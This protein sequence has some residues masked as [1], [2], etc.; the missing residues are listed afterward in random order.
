[1]EKIKSSKQL[2]PAYP[3]FVK[4]PFFSLW[5]QSDK[6]NESDTVFWTGMK[7][8]S[9]GLVHCDGVAYSFMGIVENTKALE[10]T[11]VELTAFT[12][13]YTFTCEK[14]DLKV[15]FISPLPLKELDI[16]ALPVCYLTYEIT[17]KQKLEKCSIAF[18]LAEDSCYDKYAMPVRGGIHSLPQGETA[19]FGLKKQL[20]MSQST[21]SSAAEWGHWFLTG[22]KAM[23]VDT[24]SIDHFVETG[25]FAFYCSDWINKHLM[26]INTHD[27]VETATSGK[28]TLAFDDSI[29]IFY[30]GDWLKGYWFEDGKD[31]FDAIAY[32]HNEYDGILALLDTYEKD[33]V[34]R[35]E[36][37]GEDY[38][39]VLYGGLRQS[40][41][42]HKLVKNRKG[43]VAFLSKECHSNG[44]I[45]TVDV[46]YPSVPLY[47]LYNPELVKGML[48]PVFEFAEMP[49]WTYDFAP[50]D[51]GTY[52][53]VLGQIYAYNTSDNKRFV[54]G[55]NGAT[56]KQVNQPY[57]YPLVYN[58]PNA[59]GSLYNFHSQMP[60]EECGNMLIMTAATLA[61]DGD[62]T[63]A[64][65][66]FNLLKT[67]VKYLKKYGL[68][69]G[70]QLCTDDFAGH[71]DKNI[72]LSIKAIVGIRSYAY[73]CEVLGKNSEAIKYKDIAE[74]YAAEWAKM[75]VTKGKQTP[76]VFDGDVDTFA[77]KYNMMF[78]V[79]FGS[80]LFTS[81]VREK[82]VDYYIEKQNRYGVPLDSR[83]DFTKSDWILWAATLTDD[84]EKQKKLVAP[85]ANFLK[86][87][88]TRVAFSDW[89]YTTSGDFRWYYS[90][91]G[92]KIGFQNRT[93][94]GGLFSLLLKDS[95]IV[96]F[97]KED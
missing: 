49:V 62:K 9:Y 58:F 7:R 25:E 26:A 63:L 39:L 19:W 91:Q 10:Q 86:E 48:R 66:H 51:V 23:L 89:Y 60:V 36:K 83:A 85:V 13:A 46:S 55:R 73:I 34:K 87:S 27:G 50:H 69:P 56:G 28:F 92:K 45:A 8:R 72:N 17:P 65:R 61:V 42:A 16:L 78:D 12:T 4:D 96:K 57:N 74:S 77:L 94:Q 64:R 93:V 84:I 88:K 31:I 59:D 52:P 20:L 41:A 97:D 81:E 30:F 95:G 43:E 24:I 71:L 5:S 6:L 15:T 53:Y 44:C 38:L 35:A 68:K 82:E 21:D 54:D 75:C 70:N 22:E 1:M 67:W 29:S 11:S 32:A 76:L 3:L 79:L 18:T 80:N 14:F 2:L 33:I 90:G 40:I 37:Y 47:L